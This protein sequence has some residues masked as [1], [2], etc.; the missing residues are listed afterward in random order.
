[1]IEDVPPRSL[2]RDS[3]EAR[4]R[5]A[6]AQKLHAVIRH[7][8]RVRTPDVL[9]RAICIFDELARAARITTRVWSDAIASSLA[10][11]TRREPPRGTT[12]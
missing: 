10:A 6:L 12:P 7:G 3:S 9:T 2:P 8:A 11:G 1:M 4:R 5:E